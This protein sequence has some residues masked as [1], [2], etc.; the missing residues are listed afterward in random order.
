MIIIRSRSAEEVHS[1]KTENGL[2]FQLFA[3]KIVSARITV[4]ITHRGVPYGSWIS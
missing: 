1:G 4:L 2:T 3:L